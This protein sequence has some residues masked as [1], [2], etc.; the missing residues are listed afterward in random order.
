MKRKSQVAG[1]ITIEACIAF[2]LGVLGNKVAEL[3]EV[4]P[5]A[6]I[7]GTCVLLVSSMVLT[8]LRAKISKNYPTARRENNESTRS[9][10]RT[11]V[12]LFPVGMLL[13]M[14]IVCV[15][16]LRLSSRVGD[17]LVDYVF[18]GSIGIVVGT[19]SAVVII[20]IAGKRRKSG[21]TLILKGS[22]QFPYSHSDQ[23]RS[24]HFAPYRGVK[25]N[26]ANISWAPSTA[27]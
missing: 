3:V 16:S 10:P 5:V 7:V 4:E 8:L 26:G 21:K 20:A 13:G 15:L 14:A 11:M 22:Q 18:V 23:Y 27:Q 24:S 9:S 1:V 19:L 17:F 25:V 2:T 12:R 6:L